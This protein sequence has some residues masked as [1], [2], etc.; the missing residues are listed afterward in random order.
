M[1]K[2]K[3]KIVEEPKIAVHDADS[4]NSNRKASELLY[5]AKEHIKR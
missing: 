4:Q 5:H 3:G 2:R 1:S